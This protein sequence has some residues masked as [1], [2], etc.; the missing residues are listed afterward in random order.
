M[1]TLT[2]ERLSEALHYDPV[3]GVF[4]RKV[5]RKNTYRVWK[6]A[7]STDKNGYR[8]IRIDGRCY[9]EHRVAWM[10][11]FGEMPKMDID[12]INGNRADNRISNLRE[13]TRAENSQN[14][15][16]ARRDN[17][18]GYLG[19]HKDRGRWNARIKVNGKYKHIGCFAT[20]EDAHL[21][22]L[23]AKRELHPG[24]TL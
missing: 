10:Y 2:P 8:R 19:V 3:E 9:A 23:A 14:V 7:G 5:C 15:H 17:T 12:H 13:A 24:S 1:G 16:A 18:S 11:V 21:A 20:P 4:T 6:T 22:Y